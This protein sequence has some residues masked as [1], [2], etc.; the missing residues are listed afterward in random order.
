MNASAQAH[1]AY[2]TLLHC[3]VSHAKVQRRHVATQALKQSK[4]E[5]RR[6]DITPGRQG[7]STIFSMRTEDAAEAAELYSQLS[8]LREV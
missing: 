1:S 6:I 4:L 2:R 8:S 5:L 3:V 7:K